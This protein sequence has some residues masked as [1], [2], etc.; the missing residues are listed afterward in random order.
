[1]TPSDIQCLQY[2]FALSMFW[3]VSLYPKSV[4]QIP[5]GCTIFPR[6][7]NDKIAFR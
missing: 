2:M 5:N 3:V 7:I 1:M 6:K 4:D